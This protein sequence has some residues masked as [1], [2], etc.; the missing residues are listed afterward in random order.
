MVL[1]VG[2]DQE[3]EEGEGLEAYA[4]E[5]TMSEGASHHNHAPVIAHCTFI[6]GESFCRLVGMVERP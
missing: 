3:R 1:A 4:S 2:G 6:H 5:T